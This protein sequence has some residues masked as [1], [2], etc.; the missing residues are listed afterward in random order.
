MKPLLA[1]LLTAATGARLAE[2]GV[3]I[4]LVLLARERT[5][6]SAAAA[7]VLA[8]WLA[9][10]VLAAPVAGALAARARRRGLFYG[11]ALA[12][13]AVSIGALALLLGRVPTGIAVAV[14][15]AG[16]ACGPVVTGG[17][18]SLLAEPAPPGP[19]RDRAY[20]LD[21]VTYNV[22]GV[23]GP[24]LVALTAA[25]AGPAAAGAL[26][27]TVAGVS[28]VA[29]GCALTRR[30]GGTRNSPDAMPA[31]PDSA[32]NS[33]DPGAPAR[34]ARSGTRPAL[35]TLWQVRPLRAIT[36]ATTLAFLGVGGLTL[37]AVELEAARG[38]P[39]EGGALMTL[40]AAGALAGSLLTAR[41]APRTTARRLAVR[42][43]L[44]TG[45]AL[46]AA[47]L[48]A[49]FVLC[50][51]L[52]ALAGL[53]DGPLLTATLRIRADHAPA[54]LRTQVFTLGAGL[55]VTAA[56]AGAALTG[57]A[58]ALAAPEAVL[59]AVAALQLAAAELLR[60]TWRPGGGVHTSEA[61]RVGAG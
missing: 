49:P 22:A 14:A 16:G 26:L 4:A 53:C 58:V 10:H 7:A 35:A 5:G 33:P 29:V 3:G 42:S 54:A 18:S 59:L 30:R 1:L 9:P 6:D 19:A 15:V 44:G 43:L 51:A 31:S 46:A 60:R 47:A 23:G 24:A 12:V 2:E 39:G 55:K 56:A 37:T 50:A 52:F 27:A 48:A 32:H 8:A 25:V 38:Y 34:P 28:A 21:A 57:A 17:L 13:L 36:A 20:A 45:L 41:A 40:F 11:G 61:V